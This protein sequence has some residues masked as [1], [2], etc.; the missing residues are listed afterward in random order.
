MNYLFE[1]GNGPAYLQ[2]YKFIRNDIVDG[3]YE[4]NTKLPSKRILAEEVGVSTITI[5]HTPHHKAKN[6]HVL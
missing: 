1:N 6:R 2:L 5:E 3:V 4:Y